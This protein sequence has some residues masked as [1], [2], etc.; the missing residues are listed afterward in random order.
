ME[1]GFSA[2]PEIMHKS[3]V[4]GVF[5]P[6]FKVFAKECFSQVYAKTFGVGVLRSDKTR[7]SGRQYLPGL[8]SGK[9]SRTA[10]TKHYFACVSFDPHL[11]GNVISFSLM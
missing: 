6:H 2:A 7:F 9:H 5:Q 4:Q 10:P 3:R 1:S 11:P 8:C